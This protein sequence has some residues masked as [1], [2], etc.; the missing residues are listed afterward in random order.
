MVDEHAY[1]AVSAAET[2]FPKLVSTPDG[3]HSFAVRIPFQGAEIGGQAAECGG[4]RSLRGLEGGDCSSSLDAP[5]A[6][7]D[8]QCGVGRAGMPAHHSLRQP[9]QDAESDGQLR[10]DDVWVSFRDPEAEAAFHGRGFRTQPAVRRGEG[11]GCNTDGLRSACHTLWLCPCGCGNLVPRVEA[12]KA[13][14]AA[15]RQQ[16]ED[17]DGNAARAH[18]N[19]FHRGRFIARLAARGEALLSGNAM[20]IRRPT[21]ADAKASWLVNSSETERV[22]RTAIALAARLRGGGDTGIDNGQAVSTLDP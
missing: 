5:S 15:G 21:V 12:I 4:Q 6:L 11:P 20:L 2:S 16:L 18:S 9:A 17:G 7:L 10:L 22:A 3:L 8:A 13:A 19:H 14:R 1:L